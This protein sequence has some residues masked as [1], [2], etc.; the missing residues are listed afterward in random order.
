M[1]RCGTLESRTKDE[2]ETR[3]SRKLAQAVDL[4]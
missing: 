2:G 1:T 4:N 3:R